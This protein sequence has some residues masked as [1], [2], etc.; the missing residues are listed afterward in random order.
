MTLHRRP[1]AEQNSV[2]VIGGRWRG[3]RIRFPDGEGLRPTPSRLRE[4]LFNWLAPTLRD[5]RVL[6]LFAGSGV[7]AIEA[8]SRG[9]REAVLVDASPAACAQLDRELAALGDAEA[10]VVRADAL[11]FLARHSGGPFNLVFL[12]P[13]Y[14]RGL[15][16][17]AMQAL[18]A[19]GLLA[20][21]AMIYVESEMTPG[22]D[23]VPPNWR[24]HRRQESGQ[25]CSS[26]YQRETA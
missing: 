11:A 9:A 25:V 22:Y 24:L 17:P 7:L 5:S 23:I 10:V 4:T 6:D 18:E 13:P 21:G 15:L 12:D 14:H 3:R 19:R 1:P 26:L 2:Q 20:A 8:L 16:A